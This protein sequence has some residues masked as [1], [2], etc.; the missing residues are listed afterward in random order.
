MLP[1][2]NSL[3][4]VAATLVFS[5]IYAGHR[6]D[7]CFEHDEQLFRHDVFASLLSQLN[8]AARLKPRTRFSRVTWSTRHVPFSDPT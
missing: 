5:I 4:S 2:K 1:A 3:S 7:R 8:A 6:F